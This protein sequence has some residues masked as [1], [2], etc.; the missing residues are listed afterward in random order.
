MI[1]IFLE[2]EVDEDGNK[3]SEK[4]KTTINYKLFQCELNP[5]NAK[6]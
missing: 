1:K 2:I 5:T 4:N 3:F 6:K